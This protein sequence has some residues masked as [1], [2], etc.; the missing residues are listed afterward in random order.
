MAENVS[1]VLTGAGVVAVAIGFALYAGLGESAT[2]SRGSYDLHASFRSADGVSVGTDVRLAGV[3]VGT[4]TR[5]DL[6]PDTYYA[7]ATFSMK[8]GI[9]IPDDSTALVSSEGLLGGNFLEIQPGGSPVAV[10]PGGEIFDTQGAVGLIQLLMKFVGQAS[11]SGSG[12][13]E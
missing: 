9:V 3:K 8:D 4:V 11:D 6:N 1:E 5:L 12:G 13:G 2:G 10:E 7:D